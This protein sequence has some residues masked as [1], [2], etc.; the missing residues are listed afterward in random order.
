MFAAIG[1]AV[2][3]HTEDLKTP[4]STTLQ[5]SQPTFKMPSN[6]RTE[7]GHT[8]AIFVG[9]LPLGIGQ[10]QIRQYFSRFGPVA[11]VRVVKDSK[12]SSKA[13]AFVTMLSAVG[14][15]KAMKAGTHSIGG[16]ALVL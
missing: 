5:D 8:R 7:R 4:S 10:L 14:A 16:N 6:L 11:F 13:T 15:I 12:N 1:Q 3:D 2:L 9:N